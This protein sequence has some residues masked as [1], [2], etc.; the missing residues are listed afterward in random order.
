[1]EPEPKYHVRLSRKARA[2]LASI[3]SYLAENHSPDLAARWLD[4]LLG[5]IDSLERFPERGVPKELEALGVRRYRQLLLRPYRLFYRI[6]GDA[7]TITLIADGRRDMR[8]LLEQR[9]LRG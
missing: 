8:S 6:V 5:C 3:C 2:D 1:M 9:L 7:V 4:D